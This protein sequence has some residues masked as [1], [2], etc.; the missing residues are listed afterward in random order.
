MFTNWN[1][2]SQETG[3]IIKV[4]EK[5]DDWT[6]KKNEIKSLREGERMDFF[7]K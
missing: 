5:A 1:E 6:K 2:N 3:C 4:E 7:D